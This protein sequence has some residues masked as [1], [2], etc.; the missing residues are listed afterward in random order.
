MIAVCLLTSGR[1]IYTKRTLQSFSHYNNFESKNFLLL[2]ADDGSLSYTNEQE[3]NKHGFET[4]YHSLERT[5]GVSALRAMWNE[6]ARR[7]ADRILHL[8]NDFEWVGCVPELEWPCVRLY[9]ILKG[10]GEL[11]EATSTINLVTREK[12]VWEPH[13]VKGWERGFIHMGG[14]PSIVDTELL[15][16]RIE[17]AKALKH[18]GLFTVDTI[19]P[20]ENIVWHIGAV[21]TSE[22]ER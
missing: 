22:S 12:V 20:I 1:E 8:E 2:H 6:A 3:A 14:P 15:L 17:K 9:G 13:I 5:G 18:I 16:Q 4:V 7:G 19:R 10:R 11:H 21:T